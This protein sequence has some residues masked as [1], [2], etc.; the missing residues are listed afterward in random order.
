MPVEKDSRPL[1][2]YRRFE[3]IATGCYTIA[4]CMPIELASDVVPF[5][6][7]PTWTTLGG[8]DNESTLIPKC[9]KSTYA[10]G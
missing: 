9:Y 10:V 3:F 2:P 7:R 8:W 4:F 6:Y 5:E 1:T